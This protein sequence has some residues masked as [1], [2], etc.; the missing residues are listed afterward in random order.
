MKQTIARY[1]PAAISKFI[2]RLG[3]FYG[4]HIDDPEWANYPSQEE[5][6]KTLKSLG[7]KPVSCIDVGAYHGEW[8][9]T[10]RSIFPQSNVLMI[11]GQ[12][13][14]APLLREYI[15]QSPSGVSFEIALL[16]ASDGVAVRFVEMGTGSSVFEESSPYARKVTE[17]NLTKLDTL[18]RDYPDFQKANV[19][20][21]D[22]QGYELEVLK[23]SEE[24]LK[25]LEVVLLETSLIAVNNGAPLTSDV[26][27]FMTS[28]KF[29][30]FDFCSQIRRKDGVLWQ[31]DL[32]F[33]RDGII[34]NLKAALTKE[35]WG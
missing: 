23:G 17:R 20:K 31:C 21:L 26:I 32:M 30:L 8:T 14:K 3:R 29:R 28:R 19:I 9:E 33:I 16:G 4:R 6:F 34:P 10:Y 1:T 5:A 25:H 18:L 11:E 7:W 2:I 13:T 35:N 22:T 15:S 24:L 12:Q 27:E